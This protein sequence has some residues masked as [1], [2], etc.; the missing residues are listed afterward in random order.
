MDPSSIADI[1]IFAAIVLIGPR[2]LKQSLERAG[3]GI[4]QLFV[5]PD[6]ALGWPHGVQERDEPWAWRPAAASSGPGDRPSDAS[7]LTDAPSMIELVDLPFEQA[8]VSDALVVRVG[9][10]RTRHRP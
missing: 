7:T 5:P 6:R 2:L 8:A 4:A 3:D 10:V 9:A 1:A